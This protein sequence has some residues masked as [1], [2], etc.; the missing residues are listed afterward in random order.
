LVSPENEENSTEEYAGDVTGT[1]RDRDIVINAAQFIL[2]LKEKFKISQ[3]SLDFVVHAAEELLKLSAST[4]KQNVLET[5][6]HEGFT[7]ES[8][9]VKLGLLILRL[10]VNEWVYLEKA[11]L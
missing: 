7:V 3:V 2:N 1:I 9:F 11:F 5:L 8:F 10:E 4:I 6:L